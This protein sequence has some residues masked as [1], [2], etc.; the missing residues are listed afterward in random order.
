MGYDEKYIEKKMKDSTS[1]IYTLYKKLESISPS[2]R[3][4]QRSPDH[5]WKK[6]KPFNTK[7]MGYLKPK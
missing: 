7:K 1:Y 3:K 2:K 5:K 6:E 4:L